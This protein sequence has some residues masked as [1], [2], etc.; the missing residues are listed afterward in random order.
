[1]RAGRSSFKQVAGKLGPLHEV[2]A[3]ALMIS[4]FLMPS[5]AAAR[6]SLR[7]PMK[8]ETAIHIP[9]DTAW[10]DTGISLGPRDRV[11]LSASESRVCFSNGE[12]ASCV[13]AEGW[14]FR[15]YPESW[16]GDFKCCRDPMRE[17]NHAA[18]IAR[19][20]HSVFLVG[21]RLTFSGKKGH[22]FLGIND[23]SFKGKYSNS[24]AFEVL[25]LVEKDAVPGSSVQSDLPERKRLP[26]APDETG[27]TEETAAVSCPI[28]EFRAGLS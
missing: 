28:P 21:R 6:K 4:I 24:G 20:G 3:G 13:H 27:D 12:R 14:A 18:L 22:L 8:E 23:C 11:S 17:I 1:M 26:Y 16:P 2:L 19:V 7:S 25:V 15:D 5:L 10:V 9:G